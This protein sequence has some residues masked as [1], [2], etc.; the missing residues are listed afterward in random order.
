MCL[1]LGLELDWFE[2]Q[3]QHLGL[4][5]YLRLIQDS[6]IIWCVLW[7]GID[8]GLIEHLRLI[9]HSDIRWCVLW[10]ELSW[11]GV[12]L[13]WILRFYILDWFNISDWFNIQISD[14]VCLEL[15]LELDWFN[16]SDWFNIQISYG[17]CL[18]LGLELDWFNPVV[19]SLHCWRLL[20]PSLRAIIIWYQQHNALFLLQVLKF[21]YT[22]I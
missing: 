5:W 21:N 14:G 9:Q 13:F 19:H 12:R 6:D 20:H 3:I 22:L 10:V 11:V 1:E 8:V 4:I 7:V 17:V 15:G 2:T 18:E 16:I